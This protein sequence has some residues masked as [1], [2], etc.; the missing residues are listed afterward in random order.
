MSDIV[1]I[2]FPGIGTLA[3][4]REQF[5]AALSAGHELGTA[6]ARATPAPSAVDELVDA[7]QLEQET[8]VP[9]SWWMAQAR[10]RRIP[11]R[12]IGRRV[13]FVFDEV[14]RCEAFLRRE[15]PAGGTPQPTSRELPGRPRL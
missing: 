1:L 6:S 14:V 2:P 7:Q 3:M 12:K 4:T 15:S 13:R 10:G 8:G 9:Q 11:Y 5:Q